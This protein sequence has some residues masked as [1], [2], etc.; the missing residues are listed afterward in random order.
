MGKCSHPKEDDEATT[1]TRGQEVARIWTGYG[2][3]LVPL[4]PDDRLLSI[5][6]SLLRVTARRP[7]YAQAR[8]ITSEP[9]YPHRSGQ[10][11]Q[12]AE[13]YESAY[14]AQRAASRGYIVFRSHNH[15]VPSKGLLAAPF[16]LS[17]P[18]AGGGRCLRRPRRAEKVADTAFHV[19]FWMS[20][21]D[22]IL[23]N[24]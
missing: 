3:E 22:T 21:V 10:E 13:N 23:P 8:N 19:I 14:E 11:T 12:I 18:N 4:L 7:A 16:A 1:N 9:V 6:S 2:P 15:P 17:I 5:R 20:L 24:S